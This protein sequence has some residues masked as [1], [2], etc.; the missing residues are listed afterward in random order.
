MKILNTTELV[1]FR[2]LRKYKRRKLRKEMDAIKPQMVEAYNA[3]RLEKVNKIILPTLGKT[4]EKLKEEHAGPNKEWCRIVFCADPASD[5]W[6]PVTGNET[7]DYFSFDKPCSYE[8]VCCNQNKNRKYFEL[9]AAYD[10]FHAKHTRL[11]WKNQLI[12]L[13]RGKGFSL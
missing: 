6:F 3:I 13:I 8:C 7:C 2:R 9:K 4:T 12:S 5:S 11:S 1:R 10:K